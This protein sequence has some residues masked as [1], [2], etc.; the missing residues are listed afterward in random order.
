MTPSTITSLVQQGN[1]KEKLVAK[2]FIREQMGVS[3]KN[4]FQT[5]VEALETL[6][7][8]KGIPR[9]KKRTNNLECTYV[10]KIILPYYGISLGQFVNNY[11][12]ISLD[13]SLKLY[14]TLKQIVLNAYSRGVQHN[15]IHPGNVVFFKTPENNI[16]FSSIT[17]IDFALASIYDNPISY[18]EGSIDIDMCSIF[19][20]VQFAYKKRLDNKQN[21]NKGDDSDEESGEMNQSDDQILAQHILLS[22]L[23]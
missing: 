22:N 2:L 3:A 4:R 15:D 14:K 21:N 18:I 11:G 5:E 1:N 10:P 19:E 20:T 9:I 16:D 12:N 13:D 6:K 8:I 17:L 7:D 23:P